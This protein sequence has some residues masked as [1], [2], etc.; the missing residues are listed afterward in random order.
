MRI[1]PAALLSLLLASCTASPGTVTPPQASAPPPVAVAPVAPVPP[2]VLDTDFIFRGAIVQGGFAVGRAPVGTVAVTLDGRPTRLA[3]ELPS[4]SMWN[5][6]SGVGEDMLLG[7]G[8]GGTAMELPALEPGQ[9]V[10]IDSFDP[11]SMSVAKAKLKCTGRETLTVGA[12]AVWASSVKLTDVPA[13]LIA[14]GEPSCTKSQD[15]ACDWPLHH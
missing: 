12:Q 10:Y 13:R 2:R 14:D 4:S 8:M 15:C 1:Q 7:M 11:T 3:S 5:R 6:P 9:E